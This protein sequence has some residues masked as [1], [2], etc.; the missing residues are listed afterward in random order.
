MLTW[1]KA[2]DIKSISSTKTIM[3]FNKTFK[4]NM[5]KLLNKRMKI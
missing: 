5:I 3:K 4:G 1:T 2:Q